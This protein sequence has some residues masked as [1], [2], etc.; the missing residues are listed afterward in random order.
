[1]WQDTRW[2][3]SNVKKEK[4]AAEYTP[5]TSCRLHVTV[6]WKLYKGLFAEVFERL[7]FSHFSARNHMPV[8]CMCLQLLW[9][10]ESVF[11]SSSTQGPC[12]LWSWFIVEDS[13]SRTHSSQGVVAAHF[14]NWQCE[15]RHNGCESSREWLG[16]RFPP[17]PVTLFLLAQC[18]FILIEIGFLSKLA[19]SLSVRKSGL[20]GGEA[21]THTKAI[22]LFNVQHL[23]QPDFRKRGKI[24]QFCWIEHERP[25]VVF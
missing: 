3:L 18:T 20:G 4:A 12:P 9:L 14:L 17:K 1:M 19:L 6:S 8:W 13:S 24:E 23:Q 22:S 21:K 25:R 15:M 16:P 2:M 5:L 11:Q 10:P 7:S